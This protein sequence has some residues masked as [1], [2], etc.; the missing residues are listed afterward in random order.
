L[1]PERGKGRV[2]P[3]AL[4]REPL[5]TLTALNKEGEGKN[6]EGADKQRTVF[7]LVKGR[8]KTDTRRRYAQR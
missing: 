6:L 5:L 4:H 1:R 3:A 7:F 2:T 8:R